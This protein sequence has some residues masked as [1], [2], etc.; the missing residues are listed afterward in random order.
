MFLSPWN[1]VLQTGEG[2]DVEGVSAQCSP[3]SRLAESLRSSTGSSQF[4][5][6]I[7]VQP[8]DG[9]SGTGLNCGLFLGPGPE[10]RTYLCLHAPLAKI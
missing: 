5:P 6:G 2:R 10:S 3:E 9:G 7:D 1:K 4:C 8:A